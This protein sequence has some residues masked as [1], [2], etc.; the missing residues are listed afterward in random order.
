M[1]IVMKTQFTNDHTIFTA[2]KI[3]LDGSQITSGYMAD[4]F[5]FHKKVIRPMEINRTVI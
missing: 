5:I 3:V 2:T 1:F 4:L